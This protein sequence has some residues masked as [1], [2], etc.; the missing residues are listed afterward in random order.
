MRY[1]GTLLVLSLAAAFA[2]EQTPRPQGVRGPKPVT[3]EERQ[4][5][6]AALPATAPA[7]PKKSRRILIVDNNVG[8]G[9]HPS[10]PHADMAIELIGKKLGTWQA[11]LNNDPTVWK[12]ENLKQYDG[13]FLNNTI[14]DIFGSQEARDSFASWLRDGGGLIGN[15]AATVTAQEWKEFGEIIGARGASHRMIDEKVMVKLDLP[16]NPINA[17]FNGKDFEFVDEFFRFQEP[18]SREINTVLLSIDVA[19]TDMNQGRCFGKCTRDDNDYPISWI[20]KYGKGRVFYCSL[21]HSPYVFWDP[22]V[23][24]HFV[25]G[26]QYALGDLEVNKK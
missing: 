9:G 16:D 23:L 2:Q 6:E 4:K 20:R 26:I 13:V 18:Y 14:G 12:P 21:G 22:K 24:Q 5:I 11:E 10:I 3:P 1:P 8:R 25:A 15:H 7:K 17:A 19:R